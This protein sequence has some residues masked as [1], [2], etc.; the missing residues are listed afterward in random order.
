MSAAKF[1][2]KDN[3]N[4]IYNLLF[5]RFGPQHWWPGDGQFEII[6]GA[7]LTQNTNWT[8]VEKAI[9]SL[10]NAEKLTPEKLHEIKIEKL[11]ELIRPAG[12]FNIKA[13]RLKNLINWLFDKPGIFDQV[14][15][16][17]SLSDCLIRRHSLK[18][19][20]NTATHRAHA[21]RC[22]PAIACL[23]AH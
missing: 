12:Y 14:C 22:C 23:A 5:E 4:E 6:V 16:G 17:Q 15:R 7:V 2:I 20:K 19:I 3:L 9:A 18:T 21:C 8:N 13:K 10:K 11:A 1:M